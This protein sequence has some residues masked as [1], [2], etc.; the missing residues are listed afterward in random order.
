[1]VLKNAFLMKEGWF[2]LISSSRLCLVHAYNKFFS[3]TIDL[4]WFS[5]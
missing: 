3:L 1:M 4:A 5:G 2:N